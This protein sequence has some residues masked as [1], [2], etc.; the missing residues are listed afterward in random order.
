V[1]ALAAKLAV[2]GA[3]SLL[4]K[5]L[6]PQAQETL[7]NGFCRVARRE[8]ELKSASH[9]YANALADVALEQG[10]AEPV[11]AQLNDFAAAYAE[12]GGIAEFAGES[13]G[14]GQGKTRRCRKTFRTLGRE[15]DSAQFLVFGD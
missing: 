5:Q 12:I 13:S 9:Q 1:K 14:D 8:A 4:A 15:Q 11:L 6:T 7:V 10:A 3:E 2:D